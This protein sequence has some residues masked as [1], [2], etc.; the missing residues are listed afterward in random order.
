MEY[1]TAA[2]RGFLYIIA[3]LFY[4]FMHIAITGRRIARVQAQ[5][6]IVATPYK[7]LFGKS[8]PMQ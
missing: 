5:G 8:I 6:R 4:F 1:E 7:K 2:E 3:I